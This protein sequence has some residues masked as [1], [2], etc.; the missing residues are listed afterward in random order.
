[1]H[2]TGPRTAV[3]AQLARA[4]IMFAVAG[5]GAACGASRSTPDAAVDRLPVDA[6]PVSDGASKPLALDFSATGCSTFDLVAARCEG[7]A[8]LTLTFT[9]IA[10]EALTQFLWTFGDNTPFSPVRSPTHTYAVTGL[11]DLMLIAGG[12]ETVGSVQQSHRGYVHV[13]SAPAGAPCDVDQQCEGGLSC[14]CGAAT[15][16][17]PVLTRGFCGRRCDPE[18]GG[19]ASCP[20]RTTCRDLSTGATATAAPAPNA[21]ASWRRD[22]CLATCTEDRDCS[23]GM[24]CREL[25]SAAPGGAWAHACFASYPLAIGARCGDAS[26]RPVNAD[27]ASHW[28]AD[29]GAHRHCSADCTTYGCPSDSRCARFGDGRNL[30]LAICSASFACNDDPLLACETAGGTGPLGFSVAGDP[31]VPGA[32]SRT[33]CAP[34]HCGATADCGAAGICPAGGGHCVRAVQDTAPLEP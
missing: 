19:P 14:W 6:L 17:L 24:R 13:K 32:P 4:A 15:P 7:T 12:T 21:N 22:L 18:A 8:P 3:R 2:P 28:C 11:F 1:M 5:A 26:D 33:F 20:D 23:A 30:C 25:P 31:A 16:C 10:S 29:L 27:C 34:R 9:P